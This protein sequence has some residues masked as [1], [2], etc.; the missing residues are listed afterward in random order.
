MISFTDKSL[1]VKG[2]CNVILED[3]KTGDIIYQSS[4]MSTGNISA[5]VTLDEIRAG[6]GNPI[7]GFIPKDSNV[8][9]DFTAADFS[10]W[11][12]AAQMGASISYSAPV[13]KCQIV[14]ASGPTL[15]I[16]VSEGIPVAELGFSTPKAYIQSVGDQSIIAL[17]GT[18]Y[19]IST[20]GV[21][22]GFTAVSGRRYKVW[23]YSQKATAKKAIIGSMINPRTVRFIAQIAVFANLN[24]GRSSNGT[25]VGW[26]YYTIP[27]LKLQGDAVIIADQSSNDTTQIS[28]TAIA[29]DPYAVSGS[30][31]P[32]GGTVLGYMV[33]AP[34]DDAE[35]IQGVV[36]IGGSMTI[37]M[38]Y[39]QQ[40]MTFLVMNDGSL[41]R[42]NTFAEFD[43]DLAAG[44]DTY[45]S[46]SADGI[47]TGIA[48]GA[49]ECTITYVDS[50]LD[51]YECVIDI[52]VRN[53]YEYP[54]V[55]T[56]RVGYMEV[57]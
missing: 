56:G 1:F 33:Y 41:V 21:I 49:T 36:V 27:Y 17:S 20:A 11:A 40:I 6:L 44:G 26:L 29:Y 46:I 52:V 30:C 18:A 50:N 31:P 9:V 57:A 19:D 2:T 13:P 48:P 47:I 45:A 37:E 22:S 12:K 53:P 16:D 3:I 39:P 32:C 23:Y 14:T 24:G 42:P 55:G 34:D 5:S 43:Y 38:G 54:V 15:A 10:I 35:D 8:K 4:K 51:T 28:G 7:A 25:R